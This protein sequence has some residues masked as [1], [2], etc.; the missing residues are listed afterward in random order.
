MGLKILT[1]AQKCATGGHVTIHATGRRAKVFAND[2][3]DRLEFF[4]Q[5]L[6]DPEGKR[7]PVHFDEQ[8]QGYVTENEEDLEDDPENPSSQG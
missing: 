1:L 6:D 3:G 4:L 7:H 5:F 2:L 8:H